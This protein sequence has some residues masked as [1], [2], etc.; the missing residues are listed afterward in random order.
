MKFLVMTIIVPDCFEMEG[1][2]MDIHIKGTPEGVY[3]RAH[4]YKKESDDL[5]RRLDEETANLIAKE[6]KG[7]L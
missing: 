1:D 3:K 7:E 5:N 6:M 4:V 2:E